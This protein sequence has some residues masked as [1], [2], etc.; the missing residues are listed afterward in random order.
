VTKT[1]EIQWKA[2]KDKKEEDTPDVPK[3]TKTCPII[4]WTEAVTDFLDRVIGVRTIPLCYIIREEVQLPAVTPPLATDQPQST[5]HGSVE[6]ELIARSPHQHPLFRGDN[7]NIYHY[8][9]EATRYLHQALPTCQ[10]WQR[11]LDGTS[12]PIC[13]HRQ[14]GG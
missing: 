8:L 2:L 14:V 10:G 11:R 13:C 1:F 3:I 7:A 9:E 4:K 12:Q 6:A 5:E